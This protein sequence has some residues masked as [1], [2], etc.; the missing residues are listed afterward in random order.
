MLIFQNP[1]FKKGIVEQENQQKKATSH[2]FLAGTGS[3]F[4]I[5]E[6]LRTVLFEFRR[7]YDRR[8][9]IMNNGKSWRFHAPHKALYTAKNTYGINCHGIGWSIVKIF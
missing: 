1:H 5:K 4:S 3:I 2:V 9:E 7:K 8:H 6:G